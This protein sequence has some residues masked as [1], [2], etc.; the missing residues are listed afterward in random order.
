M[1]LPRRGF[2][3]LAAAAAA[4]SAMPSLAQAQAYP[5]RPV[6]MLV[7]YAP[8]GVADIVGRFAAQWLSERLG[9]QF[10]VENRPGAA[11]NIAAEAVV[12]SPPD[13]YTLLVTG[14]NNAINASLYDGLTFDFIRDIAPVAGLVR[15]PL[16]M[17]VHPSVPAK[18]VAEFIAYAKANPGKVNMGSGG[19][20]S[21]PHVA[22][23][24]FKLM[25]GVSM[26]HVPYR[27]TGAMF[28]DFLGGQVQVAFDNL[29]SSIGYIRA[30]QLRALAV[31]TATRLDVLPD[32][33]TVAESVPGY[34]AIGWTG[35]GAPRNTPPDVIET[36]NREIN[37]AFA[38][39]R[40]KARLAELGGIPLTGSAAEI[41]RFIADETVKWAKVVKSAG[42]KP[43]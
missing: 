35:I 21:T 8:G 31:T 30:G 27:G 19:N 15:S 16:V 39:P 36:L 29:P 7:G 14:S 3:Q 23:E 4:G 10:Y 34:E 24:L 26:V 43:E 22:G 11:G 1:T 25:A 37:A 2:L 42:I 9:R 33:P 18:T 20:G 41:G 6:R 5:G 38:D 17:E 40:F 13:G 28:T 12:K 32:V